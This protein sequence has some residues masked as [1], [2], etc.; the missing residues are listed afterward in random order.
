VPPAPVYLDHNA[1]TPLDERVLEAMLPF[2]RES[3]GN[4]ASR[5]HP[6]GWAAAKAVDEARQRLAAGIGAQPDELVFTS[7]ATES[8][9][10]AIKGAAWALADRGRHL[11]TCA[12]EHRA[13]LDPCARLAREG[14][15]VTVLPVDGWGR[16]SPEQVAAA[17]R[18]DTVLVSVML[19]NNETGTLQPVAAIARVCHGRGVLLHCDATQ[20]VGKIAVD[21]TDLGADLVS[22]SAH[23]LYGPK[24]VGA[25]VVRRRKPRMRLAPLLDGGG[26]EQGMRSGTLNVAGIVG[27][28]R[29]VEVCLETLA[30]EGAREAALVHRLRE[31]ICSQL[32]DVVENGHPTERLPNTLNLSLAGVDGGALILGVREIAVSSGSACS[33]AEPEPSHVLLAIGRSR[34]LAGASLRFSLGRSTTAGDIDVAVASVVRTVRALRAQRR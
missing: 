33:S 15:E 18:P 21:T 16:V 8:C 3:F 14:W 29:A 7:G 6:Y 22:F 26:H 30:D 32:E 24:G 20:A 9:N 25:L 11:V 27:F 31:G 13:V 23:K 2:L 28:A 4:P 34:H 12:T 19:A 5:T 10:L 1:T 17:L